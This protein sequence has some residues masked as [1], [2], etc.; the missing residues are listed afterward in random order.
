[1][2]HKF[3]VGD[4][5]EYIPFGSAD[6]SVYAIEDGIYKL[7]HLDEAEI[8]LLSIE[9]VETCYRALTPLEKAMK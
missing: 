7:L 3:N 5:L 8:S 6:R 1:M 4:I 9:Y 2:E